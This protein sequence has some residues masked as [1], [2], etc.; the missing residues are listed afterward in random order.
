[1]KRTKGYAIHK[2]CAANRRNTPLVSGD[3][4]FDAAIS[5]CR[6]KDVPELLKTHV[7]MG[8]SYG[9]RT[10]YNSYSGPAYRGD[11]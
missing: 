9:S 10:G 8:N 11:D 3:P 5:R 7:S 6:N 1:M 2:C 4:D